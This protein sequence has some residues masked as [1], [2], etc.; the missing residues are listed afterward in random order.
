MNLDNT[1]NCLRYNSRLGDKVNFAQKYLFKNAEET[2]DDDLSQESEHS[3]YSQD[4]DDSIDQMS[5]AG[6]EGSM[7]D[8]DLSNP[9]ELPISIESDKASSDEL[10]EPSENKTIKSQPVDSQD[11]FF[12]CCDWEVSRDKPETLVTDQEKQSEEFESPKNT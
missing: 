9:I 10:R 11:M 12:S 7:N 6:C 3:E 4:N 8:S 2:H 5:G 1:L